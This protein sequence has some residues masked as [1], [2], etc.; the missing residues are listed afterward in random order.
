MMGIDSSLSNARSV[1][2]QSTAHTKHFSL[3]DSVSCCNYENLEFSQSLIL[4]TCPIDT[5]VERILASD[6]VF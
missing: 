5:V 3:V 4:S 1:I 6:E 2:Y